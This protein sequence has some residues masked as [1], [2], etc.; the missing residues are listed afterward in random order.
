MAGRGG[1]D[2]TTPHDT[3]APPAIRTLDAYQFAASRTLPVPCNAAD[4]QTLRA[5]CGLGL[6]GET[7]EL[8]ELVKKDIGHGIPIDLDRFISE[9]G[10]VLWYL[11]ALCELH[12][13]SLEAVAQANIAKLR[14]RYPDGFVAG[15]GVREAGT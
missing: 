7:G 8:C 11:A 9:A 10:D 13:V 3:L 12:S 5:T 6:A 4:L 15:G 14:Q 1:C 2:V